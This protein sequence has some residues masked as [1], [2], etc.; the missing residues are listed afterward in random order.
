MNGPE[1]FTPDSNFILGE[2]P[3]LRSFFV[4]AGLQLDRHR[5]ARRR[6]AARSPNGSS[7][8]SRRSI[9]GRSTS[10]ASRASTATTR[11]LRERV[12]E[13]LG[14]HYMMPWPNR[15]LAVGAAAAPLAALRPARGAE[16]ACSAPRWAGSGRTLR[17]APRTSARHRLCLGRGRTGSPYV[18]GRAQGDA[19]GASTSSTRPRS[20]SSWCRAA[21][22]RARCSGFAPT[23]SPCRSAQTVYTGLLNERGS[24]ESD[25]TVARLARR[26]LPDR[27]RHGAGDARRRLDRPQHRARTRTRRSPTSPR[28]MRCSR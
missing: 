23:M 11:W 5:A 28:P 1:S 12:S 9:C 18:G 21:T 14:L 22:P 17:A 4:G 20:P 24:F 16:G 8:A 15:E 7:A 25:L 2:A 26:P 3:E 6:R 19:R 10:A 27:H 13:M